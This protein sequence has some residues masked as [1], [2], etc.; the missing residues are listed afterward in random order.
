MTDS[1]EAIRELRL[2]TTCRC[3][4]DWTDRRLHEPHCVAYYRE[5]VD[6]VAD[7]ITRLRAVADAA[8]ASLDITDL[9][10][11]FQKREAL[12]AALAALGEE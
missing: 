4:P 7:E 9:G 6:T 8:R 3:A 1:E 12:R 2:L 10:D 5:E 11:A